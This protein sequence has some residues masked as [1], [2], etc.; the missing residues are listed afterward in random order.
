MN[1]NRF[2]S[3]LLRWDRYENKQLYWIEEELEAEWERTTA[4]SRRSEAEY[5]TTVSASA[6]FESSL[7]GLSMAPDGVGPEGQ[8]FQNQWNMFSS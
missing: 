8:G 2:N 4:R 3:P 5:Q 1:H 7:A 6:A